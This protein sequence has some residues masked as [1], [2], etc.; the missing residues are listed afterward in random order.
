MWPTQRLFRGPT[1]AEC[2]AMVERQIAGH[3]A[4]VAEQL[5][6]MEEDHQRRIAGF[7][8]RMAERQVEARSHREFYARRVNKAA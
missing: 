7:K 4:M 6:K 8:A 3:D 2:L 5:A 1:D